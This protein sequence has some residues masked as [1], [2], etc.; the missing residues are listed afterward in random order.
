VLLLAAVLVLGA[1]CS[2]KGSDE[3]ENPG[4]PVATN[5]Q[6][7][8]D[9]ESSEEEAETEPEPEE[10][11][12]ETVVNPLTGLEVPEGTLQRRPF[13]VSIDNHVKARP[14]TGLSE[15]DL[16]YEL[17]VEGGMTRFLGVFWTSETDKLGPVRSARHY[18]IPLILDSQGIF[19]HAGGSPQFYQRV[20]GSGIPV[21]DDIK[22]AS[23]GGVNAYWRGDKR[24][25]PHNLYT[26]VE[27]MTKVAEARGYLA[28]D[29]EVRPMFEFDTEKQDQTAGQ[30]EFSVHVP[31][32]V[33]Y[34]ITYRQNPAG[35]YLRLSDGKAHRDMIDG[36]QL[37]ADNVIIQFVSVNLIK[38]DPE[39]RLNV[40]L[41]GSGRALVFARDGVTEARWEKKSKSART[42]FVDSSGELVQL[43]P[44]ITHVLIMHHYAKVECPEL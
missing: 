6:P 17:P 18:H 12:E 23:G 26:S 41:T 39:G 20:S 38:G 36:Q 1:A 11:D 37:R 42:R 2:D 22:G 15:A 21:L 4:E 31:G 8:E 34:R 14:Q 32:S 29:F 27:R 40:K 44:G 7:G 24:D 35:Q 43:T 5:P 9:E 33:E 16:L 25:P 19:A 13:L 10:E 3:A 30:L 28:E